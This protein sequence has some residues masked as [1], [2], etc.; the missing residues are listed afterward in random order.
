M[1]RSY[2]KNQLGQFT[3]AKSDFDIAQRKVRD[4]RA[5]QSDSAGV[6]AFADTTRKYDRLLALDAD[7]AKR[8]FNN[9]L[10][11]YRDVDIRLKPLFKFRPD[12]VVREIA[13]L[14]KRFEDRR[15]SE[16]KSSLNIPVSF[17]STPPEL[18]TVNQRIYIEETDN[19]LRRG[20]SGTALFAKALLESGNKQYNTALEC[21]NQ[22][23]AL[24]P[25]QTFY[26]IN[27]GALQSEMIDFISSMESN[28]QVLTL[29]NA[30]ATR[31]K[32][33]EQVTRS[34]DYTAAIHDMKRAAELTPDFPYIYYNLG[35]LYCLS[36]DL[37]ESI[38]QYSKAIELFPHLGEAYYNRGLV[39]IY[40]QDKQKGCL[41]VSKAGELGIQEAYSVIKKYCTTENR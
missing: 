21:Y 28:V 40:L 33:R 36:N 14:E 23:I 25:D 34:Y 22:A 30:G 8:D 5:M 9:E 35:N 26:Y 27:R 2:V 10:L 13:A 39:Q 1:N 7:F 20:K 38:I 3:S 32:V 16:F 31:A 37:P 17:T 29:D 4:Y 41:G 6:S 15:M 24:E 19:L 11:Q 12:T 18:S